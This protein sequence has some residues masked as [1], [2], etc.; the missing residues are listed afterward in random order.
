VSA[1]RRLAARDEWQGC[2]DATRAENLSGIV[3]NNR[4]LIRPTVTVK[5]LASH[6]LGLLVRRIVADWPQRYGS[7]RS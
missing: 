5:H 4:F 7:P 3:Y 2:S 1:P 6:I